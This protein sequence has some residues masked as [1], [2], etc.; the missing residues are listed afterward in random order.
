MITGCAKKQGLTPLPAQTV[1]N[2]LDSGTTTPVAENIATSS[3]VVEPSS[4]IATS[5]PI[6]ENKKE[7]NTADWKTY[8]NEEYGFEVKYPEGWVIPKI[9]KPIG[10]MRINSAVSF[11]KTETKEYNSQGFDIRIYKNYKLNE[12]RFTDEIS[13][14]T[15]NI[16][17]SCEKELFKDIHIGQG[18]YL[19]KEIYIN[20]GDLC[21]N[22]A[23]YFSVEKNGYLFN[24]IP[25]PEGGTG[26]VGYDGKRET[27]KSL[28]EFYKILSTFKFIK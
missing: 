16:P 7:A 11:R 24:M 4:D 22:E 19:A 15:G 18:N 17:D 3:P 8:R 10:G 26:Y 23:Y 5:S 9:E 25:M 21:F 6:D 28:P 14:V 1:P 27:E 20:G 12:Q 13:L 2:L